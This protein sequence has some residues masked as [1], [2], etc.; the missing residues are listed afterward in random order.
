M[1]NSSV[2]FEIIYED[3][4]LLVINKPAG[5]SVIQE[6]WSPLTPFLYQRLLAQY[7]SLLVVHRLDKE[8]SGVMIFAKNENAHRDL[9]IQFEKHLVTKKYLALVVGTP[10]WDATT[11]KFRLK[12]GVG[13]KHRTVVDN[14]KGLNTE[15]Q[16]TVVDRFREHTM[17]EAI[18]R[19]GRTHQIRVHLYAKGLPILGDKLY[20]TNSTDLI[21]RVALHAGSIEFTHPTTQETVTFSAPLPADIKQ[22]LKKIK[23]GE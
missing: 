3:N 13:K 18:P 10:K 19:T 7:P 20:G 11:T 22:A 23:A 8:T 16:L 12:I 14:A 2:P 17:I 6:G 5:I 4:D 9:N 1:E 21:D 15:T